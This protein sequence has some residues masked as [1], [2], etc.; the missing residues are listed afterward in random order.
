M[1]L[2]FQASYKVTTLILTNGK[3][4]WWMKEKKAKITIKGHIGLLRE[5]DRSSSFEDQCQS[6]KNEDNDYFDRQ[7]FYYTWILSSCIY[8]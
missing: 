1:F 2:Y 5:E 4:T 7:F 8:L 3:S 6:G